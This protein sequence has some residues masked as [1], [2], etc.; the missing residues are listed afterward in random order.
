MTDTTP[1]L[2]GLPRHWWKWIAIKLV[3][4]AALLYWVLNS[5]GLI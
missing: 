4:L 3:V 1:T 2:L 5:Y